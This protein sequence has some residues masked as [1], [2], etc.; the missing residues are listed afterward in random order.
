MQ[1]SIVLDTDEFDEFIRALKVIETEKTTR[2]YTIETS[3]EI[4]REFMKK[5]LFL[6]L[7]ISAF[8]FA[9]ITQ[10]QKMRN[11]KTRK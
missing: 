8:V 1:S 2:Q 10:N 4:I 3:Q 9:E 6:V 5:Y 11:T 7:F